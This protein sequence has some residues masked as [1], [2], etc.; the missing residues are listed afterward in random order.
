MKIRSPH[1]ALLLFIVAMLAMTAQSCKSSQQAEQT[2]APTI[3]LRNSSD[4]KAKLNTILSSY[5]DWERLRMPITIRLKSP[6]SASISGTAIFERD[7][8]LFISLRFLG[9]EIANIYATNDSIFV[10]DKYNKQYAAEGIHQ[11][12]GNTPI[13]ITNV[14]NLLFGR[15]FLLGESS[16]N[17]KQ[18]GK[19]DFDVTSGSSWMLVPEKQ[20]EGAEYGFAFHPA[21]ILQGTIIKS[22]NH[23]PVTI[24]Y[25]TPF[26][27]SCGP[28]A[29]SVSVTYNTGKKLLDAEINWN[30]EKAAWDNSVELRQPS[31]SSKYRRITA[32]Q[33]ALM[34]SKL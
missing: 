19:A 26:Y 5:N 1:I 24:A 32:E 27:T 22:A 7:K 9:F 31:I 2:Q 30:P 11:F 28:I 21:D 29:T 8:S 25:G 12:M 13:N 23:E 6:Q 10:V 14:Q 33:I 18:F 4:A 34:L 20:P 16:T 17:F 15:V 3:E